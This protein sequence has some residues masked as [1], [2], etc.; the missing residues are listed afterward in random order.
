MLFTAT[1][2]PLDVDLDKT[3][4]GNKTGKASTYCVMGLIAFGDGSTDAA[5]RSGGLKVINHADYKSL[6]VF[7]IFSSYTTIVYGD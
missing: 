4:L 2:A 6:N 7:G 3:E 5:A 1:S